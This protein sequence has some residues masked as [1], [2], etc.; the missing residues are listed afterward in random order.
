M[1][2]QVASVKGS[3]RAPR[4]GGGCGF[5]TYRPFVGIS[6]LAESLVACVFSS[7]VSQRQINATPLYGAERGPERA[8]RRFPA[9]NPRPCAVTR[10]VTVEYD[11]VVS[12]SHD[13]ASRTGRSAVVG[14]YFS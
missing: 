8:K 14:T 2:V 6:R 7:D 4:S 1:W 10:Y 3:P 13:S 9:A 5:G 11:A 12:A